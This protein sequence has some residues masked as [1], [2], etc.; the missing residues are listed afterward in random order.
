MDIKQACEK[1]RK[2]ERRRWAYGHAMS[3]L[4]VDG[5]T[6]APAESYMGRG[7]TLGILSEDSYDMFIN[8]GTGELLEFLS[9]NL[10]DI[11]DPA[12]RR[13]VVLLKEE[14]DKDRLIPKDEYVEYTML[15]NEADA[16]WHRAKADNDFPAF[17]PIL[18]KIVA[19]N[20]KIA[21]WYD[22]ASPSRYDTLLNEYDRGVTTAMLDGFFSRLGKTITP[23][24]K[25]IAKVQDRVDHSVIEGVF[26]IEK[27]RILSRKAMDYLQIDPKRCVLGE[28]EHP[29]TESFNKYDVRITTKYH[30]DDFL[31]NMYSVM[32][33]GGHAIYEMSYADEYSFTALAG[34]AS[35][36]MHESQSRFWENLV[37]RSEEFISYISP[38]FR[39]LFPSLEKAT[40]RALY[41]AANVSM[42]TLIRT[43]ADELT[44]SLH[45]MVRY[46]L[47]KALIDGDMK[48][49]DLPGEWNSLYRKYLGIE[50][51]DDTRGVLQDSHWSGGSFG[52]FPS[53][54]LG[55][56]Y[57][58]QI[59]SALKKDV[60]FSGCVASGNI[61]PVKDWLT[62]KIYRFGRL[63]DPNDLIESCCGEKFDA[64]YYTDYL[65]KKY[66]DI[67]GL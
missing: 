31:D 1:M 67:Y 10:E 55:N 53:Y 50:V 16:V 35:C 12:V 2:L 22:P 7:E 14:Y 48:V 49:H 43:E 42:P 59:L 26:P 5:M 32:H 3:L 30:D 37:G 38:T 23:L 13:E 54:A 9:S 11:E 8:D 61:A 57:S 25:E 51:P 4:S 34:G 64:G 15:L 52:Y 39:E 45:V 41:E 19:F 56:A 17:E 18:E 44:Y 46:E 47:E 63:M 33:E 66:S 62:E 36:A 29:F 6:V 58:L 21:E 65:E 24:V 27:Q 20:R 28:T 60:D 40:D